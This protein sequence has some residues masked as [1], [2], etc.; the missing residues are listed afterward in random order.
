MC[1]GYLDLSQV[2]YFFYN[3]LRVH[4]LGFRVKWVGGGFHLM[5]LC[6][7]HW[8]SLEIFTPVLIALEIIGNLRTKKVG[9]FLKVA[10]FAFRNRGQECGIQIG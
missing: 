10:P 6:Y 5:P 4:V 8:R 1:R 9:S 2:L 3:W 7:V